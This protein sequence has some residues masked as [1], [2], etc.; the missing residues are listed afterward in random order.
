MDKKKPAIFA[1]MALL[2]A[3]TVAIGWTLYKGKPRIARITRIQKVVRPAVAGLGAS[4]RASNC[5]ASVSDAGQ[6]HPQS[7]SCYAAS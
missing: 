3:L 2:V 1:V 6:E 4:N 5:R 7:P